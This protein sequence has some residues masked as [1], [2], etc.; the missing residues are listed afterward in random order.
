[1]LMVLQITRVSIDYLVGQ[2]KAGAQ[3]RFELTA[4]SSERPMLIFC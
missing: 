2:V 3:V 1:M 4:E